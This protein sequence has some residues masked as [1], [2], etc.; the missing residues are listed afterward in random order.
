MGLSSFLLPVTL[1]KGSIR[2]KFHFV[3]LNLKKGNSQ[4]FLPNNYDFR[5]LTRLSS[6]LLPGY[7]S[8]INGSEWRHGS[9]PKSFSTLNLTLTLTFEALAAPKQIF[10]CDVI[11]IDD[12]GFL[13]YIEDVHLPGNFK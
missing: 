10:T 11:I 8:H 2:V 13:V 5:V 7:V 12:E 6:F 1:N 4:G 3:R 9:K